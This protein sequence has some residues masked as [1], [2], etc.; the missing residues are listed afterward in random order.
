MVRANTDGPG[1]LLEAWVASWLGPHSLTPCLMFFWRLLVDR[2]SR[3]T[4]LRA[5]GAVLA[6]VGS[7]LVLTL[8]LCCIQ[9][10]ASAPLVNQASQVWALFLTMFILFIVQV[11]FA[12]I[13][14]IG[15]AI[16]VKW[17]ARA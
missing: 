9:Y 7:S 17:Q 15:G 4:L 3:P 11:L 2:P 16:L 8:I 1:G 5:L 14:F 6:A 10:A 12:P 13:L